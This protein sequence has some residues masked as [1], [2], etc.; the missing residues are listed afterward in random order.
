M[1]K[2]I[3]WNTPYHLLHVHLSTSYSDQI[4]PLISVRPPTADLL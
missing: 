3:D 2:R 1:F 4:A